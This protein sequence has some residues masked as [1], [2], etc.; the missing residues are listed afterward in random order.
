MSSPIMA[1][2]ATATPP[3]CQEI[4]QNLNNPVFS[5]ASVNQENIFYSA[6]ELITQKVS[7]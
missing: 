5:D 2:T 3:V 6:H 7:T 4:I 1:L